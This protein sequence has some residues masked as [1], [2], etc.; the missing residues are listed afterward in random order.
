[1]PAHFATLK[2]A[3]LFWIEKRLRV[4]LSDACDA[5]HSDFDSQG[6]CYTLFFGS[7]GDPICVFELTPPLQSISVHSTLIFAGLFTSF[8]NGVP[9]TY[10]CWINIWAVPSVL[11]CLKQLLICLSTTSAKSCCLHPNRFQCLALSCSI[12]LWNLPHICLACILHT[13][14]RLSFL[15]FLVWMFCSMIPHLLPPTSLYV[16]H[17]QGSKFLLLISE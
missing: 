3:N 10:F 16:L 2:I 6:Q 7:V 13:L 17:L 8:R 1:M 11:C 5:V 14:I 15:Y 9:K 4:G 12:F